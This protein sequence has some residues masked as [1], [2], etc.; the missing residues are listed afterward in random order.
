MMVTPCTST[1]SSGLDKGVLPPAPAA[2][3]TITEPDFIVLIISSSTRI[4]ALRP[5]ISAVVMMMSCFLMVSAIRAACL[6]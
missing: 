2:R 4:G 1:T 6:A 5:G 3:S